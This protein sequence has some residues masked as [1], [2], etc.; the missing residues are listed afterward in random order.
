MDVLIDTNVFIHREDDDVVPQHLRELEKH[1]KEENH[2][3]LIHPESEVEIRED[4]DKQ[5]RERNSSR[6]ETYERLDFPS[7]P[8]GGDFEEALPDVSSQNDRVDNFLLYAVYCDEV[9]FL[10]TEDKGVH[11]NAIRLEIED[12]VFTIEDARDFFQPDGPDLTGPHS[13]ERTSIGDLDLDDPIFDSLKDDY[14]FVNWANRKSDRRAYV[15][16]NSDGSLGAVLFVKPDDVD[17]IG[18]EPQ[19]QRRPRLKISTLKVAEDRWGSKIGELLISIA[20]REA[21][22]RGRDEIYLTYFEENPEVPK[23]DYFVEVI[24][25]YGFERVSETQAGEGIYL[26]RLIPGP[27]DNPSLVKASKKFYPSFF[28][29]DGVD[30]FL[31]PIQP[32]YHKR[33]FTSYE[34]RN[35]SL[36][37]FTGSFHT[38]GNAIKKAYLSGAKNYQIGEGDLLLFYRSRDHKVVTSLGVCESAH[39]KINDPDEVRRLVGKRSVFTDREIDNQAENGVNVLMFRWHQ[40]LNNFLSYSQLLE[41]EVISGPPQ[42]TRKISESAYQYIKTEGQIDERFALD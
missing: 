42:T 9:D 6:I 34:K 20:I 22:E 17:A 36:Q 16:R 23:D 37:E 39:Y 12:R 1:L 32:K 2:S 30:K 25:G 21:V 11:K 14:E 29:H 18:T 33:L 4:H 5:R 26:K 27:D 24:S 10:V 41:A 35:P 13:I 40:D 38:E 8:S 19:L 15:N 3:I 7:Y 31:I 28:D